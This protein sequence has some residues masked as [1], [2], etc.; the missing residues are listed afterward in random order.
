MH[1]GPTA[2]ASTR[3][4]RALVERLYDEAQAGRWGLPVEQFAAALQASADRALP[5]NLGAYLQGL[6]LEDLAIAGMLGCSGPSP[7][8][9]AP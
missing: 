1:R 2:G 8:S 4:P 6:H 3:I 5:Q 7:A 9:F